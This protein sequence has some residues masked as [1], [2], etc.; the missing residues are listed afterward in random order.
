[1]VGERNENRTR[2]VRIGGV[3]ATR[4]WL[5]VAAAFL[6]GALT[7][8]CVGGGGDSGLDYDAEQ[9]VAIVQGWPLLHPNDYTCGT[10]TIPERTIIAMVARVERLDF[11]TG[12]RPTD[13]GTAARRALRLVLTE[14]TWTAEENGD[15]AWTVSLDPG[16][17]RVYE[18]RFL[19]AGPEL[20]A[21][22]GDALL[23]PLFNWADG[24]GSGN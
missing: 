5:L 14:T 1:M 6:A 16:T 20:L 13:N 22:G 15:G 3:L 19:Q 7:V 8:G 2:S 18:W 17:G 23:W 4:P 11:E 9:V 12:C 24:G 21:T 10:A